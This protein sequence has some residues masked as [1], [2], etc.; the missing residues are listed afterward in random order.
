MLYR[1][2]QA[3]A[4]YAIKLQRHNFRIFFAFYM[5]VWSQDLRIFLA[6]NLHN[7]FFGHN[8]RPTVMSKILK[9][10]EMLSPVNSMI[11]NLINLKQHRISFLPA[12]ICR[13]F[14]PFI[15]RKHKMSLY[16]QLI[17]TTRD[18]SF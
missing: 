1:L 4:F 8:L 9:R 11:F 5:N 7:I 15:C 13:L 12:T 10:E 18:Y 2:P 3:T 17:Y 14:P 16:L 6:L